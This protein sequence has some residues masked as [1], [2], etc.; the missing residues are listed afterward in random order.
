MYGP[1]YPANKNKKQPS[2]APKSLFWGQVNVNIGIFIEEENRSSE[3]IKQFKELLRT[4]GDQAE[5]GDETFLRPGRRW[6]MG[7]RI[8]IW[9][10]LIGLL[11]LI[12]SSVSCGPEKLVQWSPDGAR[13]AVISNG[14]L[15]SIDEQGALSRPLAEKVVRM[16]WL[17]DSKSLLAVKEQKVSS[18]EVLLRSAPEGLH[19]N[20]VVA[21][22]RKASEDFLAF[23]GKV[24]DFKPSNESA[25]TGEQWGAALL[26]LRSSSDNR[27][28]QKL[29]EKEWKELAEF[30]VDVYSLNIISLTEETPTNGPPLITALE[31]I[32]ELRLSPDGAMVA[33]V[34]KRTHGFY[35]S[36]DRE[37]SVMALAKGSSS[38]KIAA[39][40]S[41]YPDWTADNRELIYI[42]GKEDPAGDSKGNSVG[43]VVKQT[44]RDRSGAV[45]KELPAAVDLARVLFE[46]SLRVRC[47]RDG[48]AIFAAR[49]ISLP[50]NSADFPGRLNLFRLQGN[51]PANVKSLLPGP[52]GQAL[53]DRADFFELS[54]DEKRVVIPGS[55]GRVSIADLESGAVIP[56]VEKDGT[57]DIVTL[58]VWRK[59]DELCLAVPPGSAAGSPNRAEIVLYVGGQYKILSKNW[60]ET[61]I[62]WLK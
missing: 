11:L 23:E 41:E 5:S 18:W 49:E 15:Y 33:V 29:S 62:S 21:A 7:L 47:L 27:I 10:K 6:T 25:L 4:N 37:L 55:K 56:V 50:A 45:L 22:A 39:G 40:I 60:S 30:E 36:D 17:A 57:A 28:K 51:T 16:C 32:R 53:P 58:P 19:E 54:P 46:K 3:V 12:L 20:E 2:N 44:V 8:P 14:T 48:T 26:Y 52:A 31:E 38:V 61:A 35:D 59:K 42:K 34:T 24:D 43:T 9:S 13:A 1:I